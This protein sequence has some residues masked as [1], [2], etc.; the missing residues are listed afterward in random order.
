[1][2]CPNDKPFYTEYLR[3]LKRK[4]IRLYNK[5]KS[6]NSITKWNNYKHERNFYCR[7]V[8]RCKLEY[9]NQKYDLLNNE[10][11]NPKSY[12]K[13]AKSTFGFTCN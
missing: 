3:K 6:Q 7:E 11:L 1:M 12:F 10:I 4:V 2:I 13:L 5:A 8:N 9:L